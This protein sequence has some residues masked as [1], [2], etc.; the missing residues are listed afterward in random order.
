RSHGTPS[1]PSHS[2]SRPLAI[3]FPDLKV[4]RVMVSVASGSA[5]TAGGLTSGIDLALHVVDRYFGRDV[6][7]STAYQLE[8]LGESWQNPAS[9]AVYAKAAISTTEHPLCPLCEM[10]VDPKAAPS[11]PLQ[12]PT[13]Y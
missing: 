6:A 1:T 13:H 8:H 11:S 9:N 7:T 4:E 2:S 10:E 3:H 12:G 5:A